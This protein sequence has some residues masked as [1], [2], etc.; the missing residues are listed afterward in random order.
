MNEP[1]TVRLGSEKPE[2]LTGPPSD[3][4]A[5]VCDRDRGIQS[6]RTTK[7]LITWYCNDLSL[8]RLCCLRLFSR[9]CGIPEGRVLIFSSI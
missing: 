9:V 5:L 4:E 3:S 6:P 7:A 1:E 8:R 2:F